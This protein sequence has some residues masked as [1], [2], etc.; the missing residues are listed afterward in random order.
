MFAII[1]RYRIVMEFFRRYSEKPQRISQD[2]Q[3]LNEDMKSRSSKDEVEML[4]ARLRRSMGRG[5][6]SQV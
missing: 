4:A 1:F 2:S 6:W 3:S 5:I